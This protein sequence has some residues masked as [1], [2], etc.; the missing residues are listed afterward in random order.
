MR[1][2]IAAA[3]ALIL[4]MPDRALAEPVV[5]RIISGAPDAEVHALT[6]SELEA[7]PQIVFTTSTVWTDRPVK[8]SGPAVAAVLDAVGI[9]GET[10]QATALNDYAVDIPVSSLEDRAPIIA[11]RIDGAPF[12]LREKGPLWIVYPYDSAERYR[13]ETTYGRS[14][15]QLKELLVR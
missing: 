11:T 7:M 12:S 3:T 4:A 8:F 10:V 5:L 14:I 1:L 13:S 9:A 15:W 2:A 6:M